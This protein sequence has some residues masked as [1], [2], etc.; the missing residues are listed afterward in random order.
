MNDEHNEPV[1]SS[2]L[3]DY[4]PQ[5]AL[6]PSGF[7]RPNL[8]PLYAVMFAMALF[9]FIAVKTFEA[10][11]PRSEGTAFPIDIEAKLEAMLLE[12]PGIALA[13]LAFFGIGIGVLLLYVILRIKGIRPVPEQPQNRVS[14]TLGSLVKGLVVA[15]FLFMVLSI[16]GPLLLGDLLPTISAIMIIDGIAKVMAV[17]WILFM[18]K[19]EYGA[20]PADAGVKVKNSF[21][22]VVYGFLTYLA[23]MPIFTGANALWRWLGESMGLT[24]EPSPIIGWLLESD[25]ILT[26]ALVCF[27]AVVIAPLVEEFFFRGFTYPALRRRLG[28]WPAILVSSAYFS[29]IHFDF[30]SFLPIMILGV[31]MAYLYERRQSIVA[32]AALHCMN[33]ARVVGMLLLLRFVS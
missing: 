17:L 18:L 15:F 27:S 9:A 11:V 33:N 3:Q 30:F 19:F 5:P 23:I 13:G 16:A 26:I 4:L 20:R 7:N 25:S 10:L 21:R 1:G 32:P 14:W 28:V 29:L 22:D 31:A 8:S 24:Y 6:P 2:G 12:S